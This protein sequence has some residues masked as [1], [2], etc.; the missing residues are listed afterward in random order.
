MKVNLKQIQ[1]SNSTFPCI[2][3]FLKNTEGTFIVLF[4]DATTGTVIYSEI[5]A[6]PIGLY[7]DEWIEVYD[8]EHWEILDSLTLEFVSKCTEQ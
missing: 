5:N 3:K 8:R 1:S 7:L 4:T 6:N 2:A